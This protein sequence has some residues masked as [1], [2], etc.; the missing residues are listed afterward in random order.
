MVTMEAELLR[1]QR[2]RYKIGVRG[3][4]VALLNFPNGGP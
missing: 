3:L 4:E 2:N 1:L